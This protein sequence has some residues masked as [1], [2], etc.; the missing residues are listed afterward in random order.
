MWKRGGA[1]GGERGDM[2]CGTGGEAR[3]AM[4][5]RVCSTVASEATSQVHITTDGLRS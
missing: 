2:A 4:V 1:T 5:G 3:S